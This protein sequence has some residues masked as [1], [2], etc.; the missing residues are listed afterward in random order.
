MINWVIGGLI[1]G[2]AVYIIVHTIIK[3]RKGE[4]ACGCCESKDNECNCK[5]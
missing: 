1:V 3:L 2:L 4:T 5:K